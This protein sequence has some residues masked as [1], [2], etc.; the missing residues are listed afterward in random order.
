MIPV[1]ELR[2]GSQLIV[3]DLNMSDARSDLDD[4]IVGEPTRRAASLLTR[5]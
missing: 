1:E 3:N 5:S 2:S 4:S